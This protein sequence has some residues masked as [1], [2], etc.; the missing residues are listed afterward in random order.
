MEA[1][2]ITS[3]SDLFNFLDTPEWKYWVET[4]KNHITFSADGF[5]RTDE[6]KEWLS[7]EEDR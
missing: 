7:N 4:G 3:V 6:Y 1:L 5:V 2:K